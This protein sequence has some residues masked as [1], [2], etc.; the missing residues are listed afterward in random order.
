[1]SV[2]SGG[3]SQ[4]GIARSK[5]DWLWLGAENRQTEAGFFIG[6]NCHN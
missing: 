1:M 3:K 2:V 4:P 5:S 6:G